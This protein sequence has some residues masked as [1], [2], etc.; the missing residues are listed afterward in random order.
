V[1]TPHERLRTLVEGLY[2][3]TENGTLKWSDKDGFSS[4]IADIGE[5]RVEILLA[6]GDIRINIYDVLGDEVDT[7][8]DTYFK[9]MKPVKLPYDSY[10]HA[11]TV[12]H[13]SARRSATGADRIIDS[14]ISSLGAEPVRDDP[15]F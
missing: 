2:L 11:M 7:F 14:M 5:N 3:A 15:I 12:L 10:Y 4:Y 9:E 6:G 13:Q 8:D 1:S